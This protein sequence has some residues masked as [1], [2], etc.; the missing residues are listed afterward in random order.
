MQDATDSSRLSA[1]LR[2]L[3]A[4]LAG[5]RFDP[6][7]A[8]KTG[9]RT[10]TEGAKNGDGSVDSSLSSPRRTAM[11]AGRKRT[12][13]MASRKEQKEQARQQRLAAEQASAARAQRVRRMQMLGG[14]VVIAVAI[15]VVAIAVSSSGGNGPTGILKNKAQQTQTYQ[16][17]NKLLSGI[18]ETGTTLG[19]PKAP[20]TMTYFGDLECPIC[21]E[22]TL[23]SFTQ[24]VSSQ[25]RSG[26]VKVV[27]RSFCTATCNDY[28]NGQSIFSN[29]QVAAYSA[30]QQKQ[31]WYYTELFYHEQGQEGSNY[32]NTQYLDQLAEQIPSL[33]LKTWQADQKNPAL[34][35][36]VQ[37]DESAASKDGLTGTPTIIMT[38]AKG[39]EPAAP[40]T[41]PSYGQLISTMN[42]V[43]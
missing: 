24:F 40:G 25:V 20:I 23:T 29:Q 11:H 14:V 27:Y 43:S 5:E 4:G 39:S 3:A 15:I 41:V 1:S 8:L 32:V 19:N 9:I 34:L 21:R 33:N 7:R 13:H 18:P 42:A 38:G 22:F 10:P 26:K 28:S 31:F 37:A 36:Q 2:S 6:E 17:V 16:Q 12:K 35:S 30:G